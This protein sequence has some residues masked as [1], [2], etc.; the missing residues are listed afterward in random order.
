[1]AGHPAI[2]YFLE[3]MKYISNI[4]FLSVLSLVLFCSCE[5]EHFSQELQ[6]TSMPIGWQINNVDEL[7][8]SSRALIENK[9]LLKDA[10]SPEGG[11]ESIGLWGDYDLISNNQ[12]QTII[13]FFQATELMYY[14]ESADED[15]PTGWGYSGEERYWTWGGKYRFRAYFPQ[16]GVN[17]VS[18]SNA[19]T[20]VFEWNSMLKQ[21]DL[22]VAYNY[23]DT[24]RWNM[25]DPV[26][27]NF[28]HALSAL[29]FNFK[30]AEGYFADDKLTGLW[31]ENSAEDDF[32]SIGI[33]AYGETED[34][35]DPEAMTWTKAYANDPG[36][37]L[38]KWTYTVG[39]PFSRTVGGA[40]NI[41]TAYTTGSTSGSEYTANDG[42]LLVIPQESSGNVNLCFTTEKGGEKVYRAKLPA[43]TGTDNAFKP[44][45][46]YN[47]TVT[48]SETDLQLDLSIANWNRLESSY[49]IKF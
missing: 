17:V 24:Q 5:K 39:V 27:L 1:M 43:N 3:K 13:G 25:K 36:S 38:Y 12:Q 41:A 26:P 18:S 28:R 45:Y 46:K 6:N 30:F 40:V 49:D 32:A 10:C 33:M 14:G 19:T 31:L 8:M 4:V 42:W 35:D 20:F 44:G 37:E 34:T 9:D 7:G 21:L 16:N 47:Y 11:A 2:C 15:S 22:M 48:I 29:K 23:I